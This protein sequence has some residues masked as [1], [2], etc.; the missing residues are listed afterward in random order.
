MLSWL[1][2]LDIYYHGSLSSR[3]VVAVRWAKEAHVAGVIGPYALVV[4]AD[5]LS[6]GIPALRAERAVPAVALRYPVDLA[7][8]LQ[9]LGKFAVLLRGRR[10]APSGSRSPLS[11]PRAHPWNR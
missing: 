2:G 5:E 8:M 6:L 10:L 11:R 1:G 3:D 9:A 4:K 7:I